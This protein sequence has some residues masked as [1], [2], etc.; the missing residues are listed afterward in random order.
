MVPQ[1]PRVEVVELSPECVRALCSLHFSAEERHEVGM[2]LLQHPHS[3][4]AMT[5]LSSGES[6]SDS[7]RAAMYLLHVARQVSKEGQA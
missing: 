5:Q 3:F 6:L 4:A 1:D 2:A 7:H